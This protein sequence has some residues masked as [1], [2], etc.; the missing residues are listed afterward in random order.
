MNSIKRKPQFLLVGLY[1]FAAD[2][3]QSAGFIAETESLVNT[4]GGEVVNIIE[5]NSARA[6][7][8]TYIG[9]GKTREIA[10]GITHSSIDVVLIND[11]LK[12]N[13][14]FNLKKILEAGRP[15]ILVWDRVDLILEIFK[16]HAS[17]AE[18]KLQIKLAEV[19]H[20]GPELHGMGK[21]LSQQGGG[22]GTRGMGET[23]TEVKKRHWRAEI[24]QIEKDL[25]KVT[26]VRQQQ[27]A[28]RKKS[29]VPTVS[30]VGYTNAGKSTLFNALTKKDNLVR[31]A[32]FA[33]LDSAVG[34]L[35]LPG[36]N[37]EVYISDTI[38]FIQQLP[39]DLIE[40]FKST[41]MET[42]NADV[43]IHLIDAA[44]PDLIQKIEAVETILRELKIDTKKQL[45]V[46]NKID[47]PSEMN[48][49]MLQKLQQTYSPLFISAADGTG[50]PELI[51][52]IEKQ[53]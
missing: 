38:G 43:L 29:G 15:D 22:I 47:K 4:Y 49:K 27:M 18:A 46:F 35:Y 2:R 11:S 44:D 45:Y 21:D 7:S 30:I 52:A 53:L 6:D 25:E 31:N 12:S 41:L 33:T 1:D 19:K 36:I 14:L 17:T 24:K 13:Q 23:G 28:K 16:K 42:L 20:M 48:Q 39:P 26:L 5:Q 9:K 51:T 8:G 10:V 37:Q 50:L 40:S 3:R 32:P 34:S